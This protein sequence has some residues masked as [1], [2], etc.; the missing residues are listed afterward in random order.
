V[1]RATV[2]GM[3]VALAGSVCPGWRG[4]VSEHGGELEAGLRSYEERMRP[5]VR[6]MQRIPPLMPAVFAPYM[7]WVLWLRNAVFALICWSGLVGLAHKYLW[8]RSC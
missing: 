1:T 5:I 8:R 7:A 4:L 6:D 2:T 3:S